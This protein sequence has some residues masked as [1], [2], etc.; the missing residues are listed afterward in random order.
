MHL[1]EFAIFN[2]LSYCLCFF[3]FPPV[4]T[5]RRNVD[6]NTSMHVYLYTLDV[7]FPK[8]TKS[9]QVLWQIIGVI[10]RFCQNIKMST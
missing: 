7:G 5:H 8:V 2:L 9:C 6:A 3:I 4:S 1:Q 10:Q